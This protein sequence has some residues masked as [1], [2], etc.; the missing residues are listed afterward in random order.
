LPRPRRSTAL[1]RRLG[2]DEEAL[3][4]IGVFVEL[5]VEQGRGLIDLGHPVAIGTS[6]LGH[7]R[8]RLTVTGEGDH[9]R[10]TLMGDRRDPMVAAG[11]IIVVAVRDIARPQPD[12]RATVG[13]L[14]P[15]P[16]G[17]NVIASRTD[18][19][20]DVRHPDDA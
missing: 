20:L 19:W 11:A 7:G 17:T 8:W 6:I 2:R 3:R 10:T 1:T 12:A 18:M 14:I 13:R 5:H 4:R 15:I 16:G 9:A